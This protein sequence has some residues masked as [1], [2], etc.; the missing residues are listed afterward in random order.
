MK[1]KS[2]FDRYMLS[3]YAIKEFS[4]EGAEGMAESKIQILKVLAEEIKWPEALNSKSGDMNHMVE[5]FESLS[6]LL[7]KVKKVST[8]NDQTVT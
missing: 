6:G 1:A 4:V 5:M 7:D 8:K 2:V 3:Y